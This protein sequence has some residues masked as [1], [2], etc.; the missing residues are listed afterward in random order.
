MNPAV[1]PL[2]DPGPQAS[3]AGGTVD[4]QIEPA[5]PVSSDSVSFSA[6]GLP[7]GAVHQPGRADHRLADAVGSFPGW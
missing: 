2:L 1:I 3:A 7:P 4:L 6:A 5:D